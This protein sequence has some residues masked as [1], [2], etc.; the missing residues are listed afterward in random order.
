MLLCASPG[1]IAKQFYVAASGT[2]I[3]NLGQFL[4]RFTTRDGHDGSLLFQLASVNQALASVSHL[5]N[6]GFCVV[7]NKHEGKEVSYILHKPIS[8]ILHNSGEKEGCTYL[9]LGQRQKLRRVLAR[10]SRGRAKQ[11]FARKT[12][13]SQET[14]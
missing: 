2:R 11:G 6:I 3:R 14:E 8:F 13:K 7:F 10:L 5:A 9:T 4:L 1:S 12:P